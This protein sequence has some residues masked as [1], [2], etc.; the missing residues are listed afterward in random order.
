MK[1]SYLANRFRDCSYFFFIYHR[2]STEKNSW[3]SHTKFSQL[4]LNNFCQP[5]TPQHFLSSLHIRKHFAFF[6]ILATGISCVTLNSQTKIMGFSKH[7]FLSFPC[8]SFMTIDCKHIMLVIKILLKKKSKA[9]NDETSKEIRNF[10]HQ[11]NQF[12]LAHK[13]LLSSTFKK[14]KMCLMR[15]SQEARI[16]IERIHFD[17]FMSLLLTFLLSRTLE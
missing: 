6:F 12:R 8:A 15:L 4:F 9:A 3:I 11:P 16:Y 13:Y 1:T 7:F 2:P 10:Y 17:Y 14:Y 5:V